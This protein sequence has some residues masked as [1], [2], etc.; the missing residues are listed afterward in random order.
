MFKDF[1]KKILIWGIIGILY[2]ITNNDLIYA[3]SINGSTNGV[4]YVGD[5]ISIINSEN[6]SNNAID[7]LGGNYPIVQHGTLRN[8]KFTITFT[9]HP[10]D[11]ETQKP[12]EN[13]DIIIYNADQNLSGGTFS[14]M[15]GKINASADDNTAFIKGDKLKFIPPENSGEVEFS[16]N[17]SA[18]GL[19]W[20]NANEDI[21][22]PDN[23][24]V[25]PSTNSNVIQIKVS[26]NNGEKFY[27]YNTDPIVVDTLAPT[28]AADTDKI[29]GYGIFSGATGFKTSIKNTDDET[30]EYNT[31]KIGDS[32]KYTLPALTSDPDGETY[33]IDLTPIELAEDFTITPPSPITSPA[34][35][36]TALVEDEEDP[37]NGGEG[38]G[39]GDG[40]GGGEIS[41]CE[42]GC[43]NPEA[44]ATEEPEEEPTEEEKAAEAA[45]LRRTAPIDFSEQR[46]VLTITDQHGNKTVV[47]TNPISIDLVRPIFTATALSDPFL[48]FDHDRKYKGITTEVSIRIPEDATGDIS[49]FSADFS[50]IGL[51]SVGDGYTGGETDN[52][53]K[54][55]GKTGETKLILREHDDI[56]NPAYTK[57]LKF[58]DNAGNTPV[59]GEDFIRTTKPF[60]IDLIRPVFAVPLNLL[61]IID[62]GVSPANI[63]D[64]IK[65]T[66]PIDITGDKPPSETETPESQITYSIDLTELGGT[67][68]VFTKVG[69]DKTFKITAGSLNN[70]DFNKQLTMYD[71]ALNT[72]IGTSNTIKVDN[73]PPE[74]NFNCGGAITVLNFDRS[75]EANDIA[76]YSNGDPDHIQ[77]SLNNELEECDFAAFK[78]N[79]ST[80]NPV[81]EDDTI[82]PANGNLIDLPLGIGAIDSMEHSLVLTIIDAAGNEKDFASGLFK[83]DNEL[84]KKDEFQLYEEPHSST[85]DEELLFKDRITVIFRTMMDDIVSVVGFNPEVINDTNLAKNE[86]KNED[87]QT[88]YFF[89]NDLIVKAGNLIRK[90]KKMKYRV[91]DDAGNIVDFES[92]LDLLISNDTK[93]IKGGGGGTANINRQDVFN[94]RP[95]KN[96]ARN[97]IR[98]TVNKSSQKVYDYLNTKYKNLNTNSLENKLK[99]LRMHGF[100]LG[101]EELQ[102]LREASLERRLNY[103]HPKPSKIKPIPAGIDVQRALFLKSRQKVIA[104]DGT[105]KFLENKLIQK[106]ANGNSFKERNLKKNLDTDGGLRIQNSLAKLKFNS[107]PKKERGLRKSYLNNRGKFGFIK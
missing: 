42:A 53:N 44:G 72:Q 1:S 88:E 49:S 36:V 80:I 61:S 105:P 39:S 24:D 100:D 77:F 55:E 79:L 65:I 8:A 20:V 75:G 81:M 12:D 101:R 73:K 38:S 37:N 2:F 11:D 89:Q 106:L 7:I 58:Y 104:N 32:L 46:F 31:F 47:Q 51:P 40:S 54:Y 86:R 25:N 82:Y 59:A 69:E 95:N 71:K 6:F 67:K 102:A 84:I 45:K 56:D 35:L 27:T 34:T 62:G 30:I 107:A 14:G 92:I 9:H 18:F 87:N 93:K 99:N 85:P 21:T 78:A 90:F 3:N 98:N 15:S 57:D 13:I 26:I 29:E 43:T 17:L 41:P 28:L 50:D 19:D 22:L 96:P 52:C 103:L 94:P 33:Q 83:I 70:V 16:V 66:R 97:K 5:T 60:Y 4:F 48:S 91:K 63:G 68:A 64:T 23:I 76:D 74:F 10:A